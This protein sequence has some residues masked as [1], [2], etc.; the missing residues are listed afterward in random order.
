MSQLT[1]HLTPTNQL[2]PELMVSASRSG[3]MEYV[4]VEGLTKGIE[5]R[6]P[7]GH[8]FNDKYG[9]P[10]RNVRI[11]WWEA[12]AITYRELAKW[13]DEHR[14]QLPL[15][16]VVQKPLFLGNTDVPLPP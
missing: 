15:L 6:L 1:P 16:G 2:T 13:P 4:A 7:D 5:V 12:D 9:Y 10:R 14:E 8:T 11:Q 3:Q